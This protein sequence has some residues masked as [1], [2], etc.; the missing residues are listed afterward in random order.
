MS[1]LL[2]ETEI[3]DAKKISIFINNCAITL[4]TADSS[5]GI[6]FTLSL[7]ESVPSPFMSFTRREIRRVVAK[8]VFL[9]SQRNGSRVDFSDVLDKNPNCTSE[10]NFIAECQTQRKAYDA[11]LTDCSG[12][13]CPAALYYSVLPNIEDFFSKFLSKINSSGSEIIRYILSMTNQRNP[14]RVEINVYDYGIGV[15]FTEFLTDYKEYRELNDPIYRIITTRHEI[16][17]KTTPDNP[18]RQTVISEETLKKHKS[19]L[20]VRVALA[21]CK[22]DR[23]FRTGITFLDYHESNFMI[24]NS[25]DVKIIDFGVVRENPTPLYA[26]NSLNIVDILSSLRLI[27][28]TPRIDG[29]NIT[30]GSQFLWLGKYHRCVEIYFDGFMINRDVKE[31]KQNVRSSRVGYSEEFVEII[32][33]IE[34]LAVKYNDCSAQVSLKKGGKTNRRKK[35]KKKSNKKK[36]NK[37]KKLTVKRKNYRIKKFKKKC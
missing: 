12:P 16:M 20:F 18:A 17:T 24:N 31:A 3:T 30:F 9:N 29:T 25:G 26:N 14:S 27:F 23:L 32:D 2:D 10:L 15:F 5:G 6:S 22:L 36:S 19:K 7:N 35:N 33:Y 4:L 8:I 37:K 28:S 21:I 1:A 13:V 11:T 34:Q